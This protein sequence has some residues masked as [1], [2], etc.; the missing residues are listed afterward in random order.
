MLSEEEIRDTLEAV[1]KALTAGLTEGTIDKLRF[2]EFISFT[3]GL[4]Y[5]LGG[6]NPMLQGGVSG[7]TKAAREAKSRE[8]SHKNN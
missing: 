3:A 1:K 8:E 5:A 4:E 6:T 2:I 7:I